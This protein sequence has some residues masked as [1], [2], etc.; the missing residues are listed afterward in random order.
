MGINIYPL[1][2]ILDLLYSNF[3]D[4]YKDNLIEVFRSKI[5][6]LTASSSLALMFDD[7]QTA[8]AL[9]SSLEQYRA[10]SVCTNI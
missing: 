10:Y 9:L 6:L 4:D 1:A 3:I 2:I 5:T 8:T 7:K